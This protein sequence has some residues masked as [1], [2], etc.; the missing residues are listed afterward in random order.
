MTLHVQ[1]LKP[2]GSILDAIGGTPLIAIDGIYAKLEFLNPSGSIKARIA[3]YMIERAERE[4]L[5]HP[6]DTIVEATSGNT[7]NALAL[8]AAV[9]GYRRL[10]VMPDGLSQERVAISRAYGAEVM[11]CGHFHVADAIK[12]AAELGRR[13]GYF[14]PR[15]FDSE[16][17]V[18]ENREILGPEILA[19]L[20]HGTVPDA[21]VAGVGTG[22]TL[23]GLG[24][25]FR[26]VNPGVRLYAVEPLESRTLLCGEIGTHRIEGISDGFV[27]T[28]FER[29]R[30]MINGVLGIS[31]DD[32][33]QAMRDLARSHGLLCGP[34]SGANFLVAKAIKQQH[35]ELETIV[36]VFS[37]TGQKYLNDYFIADDAVPEVRSAMAG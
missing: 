6:G 25:A 24:Q 16:W 17:N 7:G 36:T 15:Q 22:G 31:S 19:Q 32:A 35:P 5:L 30:G 37:D 4:G 11:F 8:V 23:I 12:R 34:S 14:C 2:A 27:P 26:A 10:V 29:H 33:V 3:L 21:L 20:P 9:K 18:E 1:S 28:I 13:P